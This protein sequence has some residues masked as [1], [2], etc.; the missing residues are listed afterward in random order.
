MNALDDAIFRKK[1]ELAQHRKNLNDMVAARRG[2]D[3]LRTELESLT[4]E[5]R[6]TSEALESV[7]VRISESERRLSAD[8]A[9]LAAV[10]EGLEYPSAEEVARTLRENTENI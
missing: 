7:M 6:D 5:S 4:R 8:K 10:T 1:K 3:V 9:E 2:L